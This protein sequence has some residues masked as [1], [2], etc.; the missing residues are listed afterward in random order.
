MFSSL[1][2]LIIFH[3]VLVGLTVSVMLFLPIARLSV[4][5]RNSTLVLFKNCFIDE[6][7]LLH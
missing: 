3:L 5:M 1:A 7:Y 6:L 2:V 4:P